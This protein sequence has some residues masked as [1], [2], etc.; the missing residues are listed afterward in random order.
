MRE[1]IFNLVL[2]AGGGIAVAFCAFRFLGKTF[3]EKHVSK[4]LKEKQH[5]LDSELEKLKTANIRISHIMTSLYTEEKEAIKEIAEWITL[6]V[7]KAYRLHHS[8][9]LSDKEFDVEF[10][11]LRDT[12]DSLTKST[13]K[14]R[15]LIEDK[16]YQQI[17]EITN[18]AWN[19]AGDVSL[20]AENKENEDLFHQLYHG[21]C[22][23]S[24]INERGLAIIRELD[25]L[26]GTMREYIE[27]KK[28]EYMGN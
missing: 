19:Y 1:I 23:S 22:Q 12:F 13:N 15:V 2:S 4:S 17:A 16:L 24:S 9:F 25:E 27:G 28:R 8:I 18:T 14:N 11:S 5:E 26:V 20:C 7:N 10:E 21:N 3:I 6:A